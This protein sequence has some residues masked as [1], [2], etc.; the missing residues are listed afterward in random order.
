MSDETNITDAF[1]H[2]SDK[3]TP[4]LVH[5]LTQ[6]FMVQKDGFLDIDGPNGFLKLFQKENIVRVVPWLGNI[7]S[8]LLNISL[9]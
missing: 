9:T 3:G 6:I 4:W 8:D 1:I 2:I 7:H 5:P